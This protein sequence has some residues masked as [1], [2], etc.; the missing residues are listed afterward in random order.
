MNSYKVSLHEKNASI[1]I[2]TRYQW[3]KCHFSALKISDF[4]ILNWGGRL[5]ST[6]QLI[7]CGLTLDLVTSVLSE[8]VKIKKVFHEMKYH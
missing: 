4:L 8:S 7:D 6:K 1:L 5:T 3:S 2:T